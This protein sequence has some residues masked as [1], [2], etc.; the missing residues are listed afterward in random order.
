MRGPGLKPRQPKKNLKFKT[1]N[2][3][4]YI[5]FHQNLLKFILFMKFP[6]IKQD[7]NTNLLKSCIFISDFFHRAD[8]IWIS[9][10]EYVFHG[11]GF[12]NPA[13]VQ[14]CIIVAS[15]LMILP[16]FYKW[17]DASITLG[18]TRPKEVNSLNNNHKILWS[19]IQEARTTCMSCH[20]TNHV[21]RCIQEGDL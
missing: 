5:I 12:Q 10:F 13:C 4:Y 7:F 21:D 14:S 1:Q 11:F 16:M 18:G 2:L 9:E 6:T 3:L 20:Y 8:L 15:S 17:T 19:H